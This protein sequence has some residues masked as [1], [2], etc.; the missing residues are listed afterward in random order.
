MKTKEKKNRWW[1]A[2]HKES[3]GHASWH[4]N[5]STTTTTCA[6]Y[7]TEDHTHTHTH[8]VKYQSWIPTVG[9]NRKEIL[10]RIFISS[11]GC[12]WILF[13]FNFYYIF[14]FSPFLFNSHH[15]VVA[16]DQATLDYSTYVCVC[17]PQA[18]RS[19]RLWRVLVKLLPFMW[20]SVH[21]SRTIFTIV[22]CKWMGIVSAIRARRLR[23]SWTPLSDAGNGNLFENKKKA[24]S[25]CGKVDFAWWYKSNGSSNSS[26]AIEQEWQQQQL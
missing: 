13:P 11:S 18:L 9:K 21:V 19:L 8:T 15:N 6:H 20:N 26:V 3:C 10:N 25:E 17:V 16:L 14:S 1:M 24:S 22:Y 7:F 2:G 5:F 12:I 23:L 4:A